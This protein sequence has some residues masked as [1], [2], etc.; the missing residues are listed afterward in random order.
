MTLSVIIIAAIIAFF[1]FLTVTI[2]EMERSYKAN[3][4]GGLIVMWTV[5]LL[6]L[7]VAFFAGGKPKV[8]QPAQADQ[9]SIR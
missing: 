8:A 4:L 6:F 7:I 9:T 3:I 1:T 5:I 2:L